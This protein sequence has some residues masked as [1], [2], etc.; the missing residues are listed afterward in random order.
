M[1]STFDSQAGVGLKMANKHHKALETIGKHSVLLL[2]GGKGDG[3]GHI[4]GAF[5]STAP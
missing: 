3:E 1:L 4:R 5:P 2:C